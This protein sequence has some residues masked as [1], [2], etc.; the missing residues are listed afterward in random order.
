MRTSPREALATA[1]VPVDGHL[2]RGSLR[3]LGKIDHVTGRVVTHGHRQRLCS[4]G[5]GIFV[6]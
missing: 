3:G 4:H 2:G 5:C 6:G 1:P